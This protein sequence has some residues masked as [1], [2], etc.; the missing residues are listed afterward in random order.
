MGKVLVTGGAGFLG[1]HL[2]D[3]LLDLNHEVVCADSL[4]TGNKANIAHQANNKRLE[5]IQHDVSVPLHIS[6]DQIYNLACPASPPHYQRDP[7][8]IGR[9][10]V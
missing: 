7:I 2:V 4:V 8:Q 6:V 1:S 9:A 5:F 3:R 10:H